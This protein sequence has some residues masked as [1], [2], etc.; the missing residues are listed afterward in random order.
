MTPCLLYELNQQNHGTIRCQRAG[1][2]ILQATP[3]NVHNTN[4]DKAKL[5]SSNCLLLA[6]SKAAKAHR[7]RHLGIKLFLFIIR[8]CLRFL[9]NHVSMSLICCVTDDV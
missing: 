7:G 9:R 4:S 2:G 5:Q 3:H 6:A 8:C 1:A